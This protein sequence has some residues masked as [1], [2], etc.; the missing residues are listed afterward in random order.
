[1]PATAELAAPA[2]A[3]GHVTFL[4]LNLHCLLCSK[5]AVTAASNGP[6]AGTAYITPPANNRP[7]ASY[8]LTVCVKGT[9]SCRNVSCTAN[10]DGNAVTACAIPDCEPATTYTVAGVAQQAGFTS[11]QSEM[12]EFATEDWP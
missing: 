1:M 4:T 7:W 8:D 3:A 12:V 9:A 11:P 6:T 5:P 10:A 2:F